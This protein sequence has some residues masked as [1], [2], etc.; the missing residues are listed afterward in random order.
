MFGLLT[1]LGVDLLDRLGG[2]RWWVQPFAVVGALLCVALDATLRLFLLGAVP[3]LAGR[4]VASCGWC[5]SEQC[6]FKAARA[7][8]GWV[9]VLAHFLS[10]LLRAAKCF[11]ITLCTFSYVCG[12]V[13]VG[14][15]VGPE[16]TPREFLTGAFA[17]SGGIAVCGCF[18]WRFVG[19][20]GTP[21]VA[22]F[23]VFAAASLQSRLRDSNKDWSAIRAAGA[24]EC[25]RR[26]TLIDLHPIV[27]W[28]WCGGWRK[29]RQEEQERQ[30]GQDV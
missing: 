8:D 2:T 29:R 25:T 1:G 7:K 26:D 5:K 3:A 20:K 21:V 4:A 16:L 22:M 30:G 17:Y 14:L 27:D 19:A 13:L 9:G 6:A 28:W 11:L 24:Q 15:L 23:A 12:A 10:L 18:V